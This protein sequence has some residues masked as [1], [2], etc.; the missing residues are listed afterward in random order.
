M[1]EVIETDLAPKAIGPYSQ[2]VVVNK[3]IYCSGQIA[4]DPVT[5]KFLGG[6]SAIQTQQALNN[7]QKV[8]EAAGSSMAQVVKTT[9]YLQSMDD[10]QE[11]NQVYESFFPKPYPARSTVEVAKL[12]LGA[13]VEFEAIANL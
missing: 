5:Q 3:V 9:I 7:L 1:K 10:F 6:S 2:G 4:I 12:P 13:L 11:V 8:L